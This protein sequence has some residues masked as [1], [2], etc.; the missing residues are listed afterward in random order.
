M[1]VT[2]VLMTVRI[3]S[4]EQVAQAAEAIEQ[5]A[6]QLSNVTYTHP[7][8]DGSVSQ[9]TDP[10]TVA[11]E[12]PRWVATT[13]ARAAAAR[14]TSTATL[15]PGCD[16]P[17]HRNATGQFLFML[18]SDGMFMDNPNG[19]SF[20]LRAFDVAFVAPLPGLGTG[21]SVG[22]LYVLGQLAD[23]SGIVQ[24]VFALPASDANGDFPFARLRT[25]N[26][27][28]R[29]VSEVLFIS[30]VYTDQ[31][32]DFSALDI[33]PQFALDN[34]SVPEPASAALALAAIG[35]MAAARR[36]RSV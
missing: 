3:Q 1:E 18:N 2:R 34:I 7:N 15:S 24:D 11:A 19:A 4:Q 22:E 16:S 10:A 26:L 20:D 21:L 27:A 36:R 13:P 32:C 30:C 9:E 35:L 17:P 23:G 5:Q 25:S 14:S 28:G 6:G 31:G 33:P 29:E 12:V 8:E